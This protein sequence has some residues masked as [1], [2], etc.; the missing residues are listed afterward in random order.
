VAWLVASCPIL[1]NFSEGTKIFLVRCFVLCALGFFFS[2]IYAQTLPSFVLTCSFGGGQPWYRVA[3]DGKAVIFASVLNELNLNAAKK[4]VSITVSQREIRWR[5]AEGSDLTGSGN[6]AILYRD[7]LRLEVH[8]GYQ[9]N[10]ISSYD[11]DAIT[12]SQ[13]FSDLNRRYEAERR[14]ALDARRAYDNRPNKL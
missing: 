12:D 5:M 11:C 7:T 2:R 3:S 9:N 6:L 13:I 4:S 14:K 10:P 8:T 1:T